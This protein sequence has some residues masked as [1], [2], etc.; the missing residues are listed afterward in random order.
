[1]NLSL[2]IGKLEQQAALAL[3]PARLNLDARA[4]CVMAMIRQF[5]EGG[6]AGVVAAQARHPTLFGQV[7]SMVGPVLRDMVGAA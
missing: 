6:G 1:M 4:V 7:E 3:R 2:R 5:V